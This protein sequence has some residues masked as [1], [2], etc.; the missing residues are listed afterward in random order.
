M[1]LDELDELEFE[2]L[3]TGDHATAADHLTRLADAPVPG[4]VSRVELLV[5]AGEQWQHAGE[6]SQATQLYQLAID[7]GGTVRGDPRTHLADALFELERDDEA[8]SLLSEIRADAPEDPD[9]YRRVAET[10]DALRDLAGAHDWSTVGVRLALQA[11]DVDEM[12]LDM[13]LRTRYRAR[14]D[15]NLPEDSYD[16]MLEQLLATGEIHRS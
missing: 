5:R 16:T 10:L 7:D 12:C 8:R 6:P 11:N 4:E 13:L 2:A 9:I 3:R 15:M 14:R 1:K